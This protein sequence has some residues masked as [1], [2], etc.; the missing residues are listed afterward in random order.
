[1]YSRL[2]D[3][4]TMGR[5]LSVTCTVSSWLTILVKYM[6]N[7]FFLHWP[8]G[9][10][11]HLVIAQLLAVLDRFQSY[12]KLW[13]LP[14]VVT[15]CTKHISKSNCNWHA[16][17]SWKKCLASIFQ[18]RILATGCFR[19]LCNCFELADASPSEDTGEVSRLTGSQHR[20]YSTCDSPLQV[21]AAN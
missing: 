21:R 16:G 13:L 10:E 7:L 11:P 3:T 8:P 17:D 20:R 2:A 1:M 12:G 18:H 4:A 15:M 6:C 14:K 5:C 9:H 19:L